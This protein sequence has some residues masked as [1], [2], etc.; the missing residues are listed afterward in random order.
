MADDR[1]P[2]FIPPPWIDPLQRPRR[3]LMHRPLEAVD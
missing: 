1:R 2:E 3:N